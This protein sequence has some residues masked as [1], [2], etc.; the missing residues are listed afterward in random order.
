LHQIAFDGLGGESIE[1]SCVKSLEQFLKEC[2]DVAVC[3]STS[4][5]HF[6]EI[7][8]KTDKNVHSRLSHIDGP[9]KIDF[10]ERPVAALKK[11]SKSSISMAIHAVKNGDCKA[12]LSFGHTGAAVASA[13]LQLGLIP[14]VSKAGLAALMPT[15]SGYGILMDVG[16]NLNCKPIHLFQYGLMADVYASRIFKIKKPRIGLL[17]VGAEKEKGDAFLK[18][19]YTLFE[20]SE[21]NF[22]GNVEGAQVFD[23]SID[24]VICNGITGNMLLKSSESLAKML[25]EEFRMKSAAMSH[26]VVDQLAKSYD[27]DSV[28]ASRLLGVEGLV[29]IGH[30]NAGEQAIY[31]GLKSAYNEIVMGLQPAIY[32]RLAPDE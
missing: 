32:E 30:G 6:S 14:G 9:E 11:K 28:G 19:T 1:Q 29:L 2:T 20:K 17:N 24:A 15:T 16:A 10:S 26:D 7:L 18:E 12:I 13:Q 5:E 31:S 25:I 21:I 3:V 27:P 4:E 22:V 8:N 23:G